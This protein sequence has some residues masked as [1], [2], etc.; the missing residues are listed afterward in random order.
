MNDLQSSHR[1]S[2]LHRQQ[3]FDLL[4]PPD[5]DQ[6]RIAACFAESAKSK[7][8]HVAYRLSEEGD[9]DWLVLH[10]DDNNRVADCSTVY[11]W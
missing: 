4:G 11:G 8:Q 7:Y 2:G 10:L 6:G 3:V 9:C 1:L 5:D